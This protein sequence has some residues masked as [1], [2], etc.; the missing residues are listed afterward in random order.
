M[1]QALFIRN[2]C[3][4]CLEAGKET[5]ADTY[6]VNVRVVPP[7][8]KTTGATP[9]RPEDAP[10]PFVVELCPEHGAEICA[11]VLALAEYGRRPDNRTPAKARRSDAAPSSFVCPACGH[12]ANNSGGLRGHVRREHDTT[13]AGIGFY[14]AT[15]KCDGCGEPYGNRQGLAAHMRT[16]HPDIK[17]PA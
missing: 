1:A 4:I 15:Y 11:A 13:L 6:A 3:D 5:P 17:Q 10:A 8:D 16:N 14:P 9:V 12:V 7:D 2:W